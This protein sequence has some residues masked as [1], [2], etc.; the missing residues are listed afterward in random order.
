MLTDSVE[1]VSTNMYCALILVVA[2]IS[3]T[4][5]VIVN[6]VSSKGN[7]H[8]LKVGGEAEY[9]RLPVDILIA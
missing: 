6:C 2:C 4:L 3:R 7:V 5:T 1:F 8:V 9:E